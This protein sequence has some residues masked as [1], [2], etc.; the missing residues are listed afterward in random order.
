MASR[1]PKVKAWSDTIGERAGDG[2]APPTT[3]SVGPAA[4]AQQSLANFA[5]CNIMIALN[6]GRHIMRPTDRLAVKVGH[7]FEARATGWGVAALPFVV[8][9]VFAV[10]G[11]VALTR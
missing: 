8:L 6:K 7:W 2:A 4:Q 5:N 1:Q 9:I 3:A 10:A 11:A